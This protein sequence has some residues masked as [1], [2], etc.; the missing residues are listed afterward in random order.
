MATAI[1]FKSESSDYYLFV[2]DKSEHE[3]VDSLVE[4]LSNQWYIKEEPLY[5]EEVNTQDF[6]QKELIKKVNA[7]LETVEIY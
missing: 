3:S 7:L 2:A 5:V 4:S 6:D 1:C